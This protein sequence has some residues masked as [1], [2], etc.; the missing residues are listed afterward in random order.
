MSRDP[1]KLRAFALAD[2]L[3]VE[4]YRR[5]AGFPADE[6]FGLQSQ[7]RGATVSVP[8]NIVEGC[9]RRSTR[10]YVHFLTVALGSASEGRYL[11]GLAQRLGFLLPRDHAVIDNKCDELL[12]TLQRLIDSLAGKP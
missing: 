1:R 4:V 9:A 11:L 6:R 10:D 5:T 8:A 7:I 12:R 2:A 3:V